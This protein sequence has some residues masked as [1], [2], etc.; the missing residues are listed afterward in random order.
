M[1]YPPL[2]RH[3]W[4]ESSSVQRLSPPR[5]VSGRR[6][7]NPQ[8]ETSSLAARPRKSASSLQASASADQFHLYA[9]CWPMTTCNNVLERKLTRITPAHISWGTRGQSACSCTLGSGPDFVPKP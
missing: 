2:P 9:T 6:H 3:H 7:S 8:N 1:S 4:A 5:R